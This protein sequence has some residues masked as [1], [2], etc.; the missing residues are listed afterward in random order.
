[1]KTSCR[2]YIQSHYASLPYHITLHSHMHTLL[3]TVIG[4]QQCSWQIGWDHKIRSLVKWL[5]KV[6]FS[7][8]TTPSN[9]NYIYILNYNMKVCI[10]YYRTGICLQ[11]WNNSAAAVSIK[12]I[13]IVT[14]SNSIYFLS[15]WEV[16][17][18][19]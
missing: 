9:W 13:F 2:L 6:Q 11:H 17:C 18:F 14:T 15:L 10:W 16:F 4:T 7:S 3:G 12:S 8:M 1:M 19:K 5:Q